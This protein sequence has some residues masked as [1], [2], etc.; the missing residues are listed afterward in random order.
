MTKALP[1][2]AT[3]QI[4]VVSIK[5]N[6]DI[7]TT[8]IK[9]PRLLL[10]YWRGS[11]ASDIFEFAG[12]PGLE[13]MTGKATHKTLADSEKVLGQWMVAKNRFAI[14]HIADGC[15]VG[16]VGL[17][18]SWAEDD[19]CFAHLVVAELGIFI[20][21]PYWGQG[22]AVEASKAAINHGFEVLGLGAI[23]VCHFLE[24]TQSQR[25][26]EKLGFKFMQ[27]DTYHSRSLGRDFLE[28]QYIMFN[29]SSLLRN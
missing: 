13:S 7:S 29:Q 21:R 26:V 5:A 27:V 15:L 23:T 22:L 20:A 10:R 1:A 16:H 8:E 17:H 24:N 25:V 6:I 14:Y 2:V 4:E 3:Y 9:T 11:E 12:Q 18:G 28:K 19:A